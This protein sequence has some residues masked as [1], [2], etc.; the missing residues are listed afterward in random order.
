MTSGYSNGAIALRVLYMADCEAYGTIYACWRSEQRC[1]YHY[2]STITSTN[3]NTNS[4]MSRDRTWWQKCKFY[5]CE[6]DVVVPYTIVFFFTIKLIDMVLDMV[7][8]RLIDIRL[9][10]RNADNFLNFRILSFRICGLNSSYQH[11]FTVC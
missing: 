6:Y 9:K 2:I 8:R 3:T 1:L 11:W 10:I 7:I 5:S 4:D